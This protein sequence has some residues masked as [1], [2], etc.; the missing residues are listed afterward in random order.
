[1][2]ASAMSAREGQDRNG[3]EAKPASATGEAGDAQPPSL[4]PEQSAQVK[5]PTTSPGVGPKGLT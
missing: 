4:K 2:R 5:G 1:M 3:L